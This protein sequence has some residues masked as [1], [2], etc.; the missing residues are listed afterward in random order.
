MGFKITYYVP[1]VFLLFIPITIW[2][3]YKSR[4]TLGNWR[5]RVSLF[6]RILL[7]LILTAMLC[8]LNITRKC[9]DQCLIYVIDMSES[10]REEKIEE[11][12][13]YIKKINSRLSTKDLTGIVV[14]GENALVEMAPH[15]P[16]VPEQFHSLIRRDRTNIAGGLELAAALFDDQTNW[17]EA[18]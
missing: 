1:L 13:L 3:A 8:G 9:E 18:L 11:I 4:V 5:Y 16:E 14:F 15:V 17:W 6:C 10:I 2:I 12:K 7:I